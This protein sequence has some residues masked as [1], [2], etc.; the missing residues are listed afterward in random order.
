[1]T[2]DE[3][4]KAVGELAEIADLVE[5]GEYAKAARRAAD[6]GALVL[7]LEDQKANLT[8]AMAA[9]AE[10]VADEAERLKVGD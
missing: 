8:D 3:V 5:V 6:F 9:L 10:R 2:A 1:M 4:L 7:P